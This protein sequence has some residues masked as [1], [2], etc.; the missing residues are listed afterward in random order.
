MKIF[1]ISLIFSQI[2][3]LT[4]KFFLIFILQQIELDKCVPGARIRAIRQQG[5]DAL[6]KAIVENGWAG[7]T[8]CAT[9][10]GSGTSKTYAI[11]DGMHR[12]TAL[13]QLSQ[14]RAERFKSIL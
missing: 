6:K 4:L 11:I 5:V 12:I 9:E 13:Q 2:I 3:L 10:V 1:F 14:E 8:I 7:S